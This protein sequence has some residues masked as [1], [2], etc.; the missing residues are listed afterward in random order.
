MSNCC[1][2]CARLLASLND[3]RLKLLAICPTLS[4]SLNPN[5]LFANHSV[6][7]LHRAHYRGLLNS[8]QDEFTGRILR[9]SS[10]STTLLS[11]LVLTS[12]DST[13]KLRLNSIDGVWLGRLSSRCKSIH[14]LRR[15]TQIP[16]IDFYLVK[17][18][19]SYTL[20]FWRSNC[21][22]IKIKSIY[23]Y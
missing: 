13:Q 9:F 3:L 4:A 18:R 2:R 7:D 14:S 15:P 23:C 19:K 12:S 5:N 11:R 22:K 1:N 10:Q 20:S 6:H 21:L 17:L 16:N 8:A